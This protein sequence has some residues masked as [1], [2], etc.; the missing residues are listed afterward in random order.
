MIM[1]LSFFS[2]N[3]P[4]GRFGLVVTMSM[5]MFVPF[6]CNFSPN[7]PLG[8]FGLVLVM[9]VRLSVCLYVCLSP[10]HVIFKESA[11]RPIL[12]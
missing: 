4:L 8:R 10:F 3:Q 9:S 2:P 12:S 6:S 1:N 11:L 5:Y 7:W